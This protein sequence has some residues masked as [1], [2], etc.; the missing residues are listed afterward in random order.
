MENTKL[1]LG[2]T[3]MKEKIRILCLSLALLSGTWLF[4]DKAFDLLMEYVGKRFFW[5]ESS[6]GCDILMCIL[7]VSLSIW[8]YIHLRKQTLAEFDSF[9]RN[10]LS[11]VVIL[12]YV[13]A[14]IYHRERFVLFCYFPKL[15]YADIVMGWLLVW[16]LAPLFKNLCFNDVPKMAVGS[17]ER[18]KQA[19][20]LGDENHP[21][22]TLG[23]KNEARAICEYI[24][25]ET[26]DYNT[27]LA[28]SITGSWGSGKT[29]LMNYLKDYLREKGVTYFDYSPWQRCQNDVALDFVSQLNSH[30]YAQ[31]IGLQSMDEYIRSLKVSNVTG[32]FNL[33]I[34]ALTR[35]VIG[36]DKNTTEFLAEASE[37]MKTLES[38]VVA[39]VDDVDRINKDDFMDVLRLI[40]ATAN[41]P[42]LVYVVAYDRERALKLLGENYGE[43]Y[44]TKIF[45]VGHPLTNI[46]DEKLNELAFDRFRDYGINEEIDSPFALIALSDY[47]PTI[48]EMK[49]FFNLLS[50]DYMAQA[51]LRSKI[52]FNFSFYAKLELLK[53]TDLL[54]YTMLKNEPTVYLE[55]DKDNGVTGDRY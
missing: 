47:L 7:F 41:F 55:V 34:H 53:Y 16:Y 54:T 40:R 17:E 24:L 8:I 29:V 3:G 11:F 25:D 46:S 31:N 32:W 4:A 20:L 13:H 15:A 48:R 52:Y 19:K 12:F 45:N 21:E 22:D 9:R 42:N 50:K 39:F 51:E 27:S 1:D 36:K 38:P 6:V 23:R 35:L 43:G 14:C 33:T 10:A 37:A 26:N 28:I 49:R 2:K 18:K 44:L 30:L 5:I